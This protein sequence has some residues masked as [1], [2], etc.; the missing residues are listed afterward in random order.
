[1]STVS[2]SIGGI[3]KSSSSSKLPPNLSQINRSRSWGLIK[4]NRDLNVLLPQSRPH[5]CQG[6]RSRQK[7]K[8]ARNRI[9]TIWH[10]H[11][12]PRWEEHLSSDCVTRSILGTVLG[13]ETRTKKKINFYLC[14]RC[15]VPRLPPALWAGKWE[16]QGFIRL[17]L[18]Y[19]INVRHVV[20]L[21]GVS[22]FF[23]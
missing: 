20:L 9:H 2:A 4:L 15:P 1:M 8:S 12:H 13:R 7:K 22:L 21:C 19:E 10:P 18:S 5:F 3:P 14:H 17:A 16:C 6:R 23:V 11:R